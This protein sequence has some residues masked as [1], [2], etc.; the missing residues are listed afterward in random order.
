MNVGRF[1]ELIKEFD[2][3]DDAE[4]FLCTDHGQTEEKSYEI[5]PSR[6]EVTY[7]ED[8]I[9]ESKEFREIYDEWALQEYNENGKVT[10]ICISS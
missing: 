2:I 5:C 1:K 10:A 9:W 6:S 4:I 3:P 7:G 8:M